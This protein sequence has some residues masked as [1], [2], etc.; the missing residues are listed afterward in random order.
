MKQSILHLSVADQDG[1]A[2]RAAYRIHAG[3]CRLG[4]DSRM[5]VGTKTSDDPTV[6]PVASTPAELFLS[7]ARPAIEALPIRFWYRP[8]HRPYFFAN[9]VPDGIAGHEAFSKADLLQ[10]HWV[11]AGLLRPETLAA[12]HKPIV[13]RLS[14]QWAFTGGCHYSGT[15]TRYEQQCGSCP[16]LESAGGS[17]LSHR[18]WKRKQS[19]YSRL[20]LT[21]VSPSNW[22][23]D[24]ARKSSLF[25]RFP[26]RV[27]HNGLDTD[28]FRPIDRTIARALLRL[29][30]DRPLIAFGAVRAVDDPR[31]GF[32]ELQAALGILAANVARGD[33]HVTMAAQPLPELLVFGA[34]R[35]PASVELPLPTHFLGKIHDDLALALAYS[36][37]DVFV[38]P[39]LEENFSSTV[40]EAVACGVPVAAFRLGGM[41]D[42]VQHQENGW[43]AEPVDPG[44]LA[45]G[46][47]WI[48]ADEVRRRKLGE[49]ARFRTL[50]RFSLTRQC[51]HYIDLYNEL[52]DSSRRPGR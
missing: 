32:R 29:P 1:G 7:F 26:I 28:V 52:L 44:N 49:V 35:A 42:L 39:S 36:A 6:I 22:L 2:A 14:D 21:V 30:Q 38:A 3:L 13:W 8:K 20:D 27:I 33:D 18:T 19:S 17:D 41:P 5:L 45:F 23:A 48:L 12:F 40:L 10:L 4:V 43:L 16:Q 34:S 46:I 31:K 11:S 51:G 25:G 9:W 24:L 50:E 37:A 15:C 47:T